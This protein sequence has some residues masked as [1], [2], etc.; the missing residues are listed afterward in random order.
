MARRKRNPYTACPEC[1]YN[2]PDGTF[3]RMLCPQCHTEVMLRAGSLPLA[4][5]PPPMPTQDQKDKLRRQLK[6]VDHPKTSYQAEASIT[7]KLGVITVCGVCGN[8]ANDH[9]SFANGEYTAKLL[10]F[11]RTNIC[12]HCFGPYLE[13]S[14]CELS[15]T[16]KCQ[17]LYH[18]RMKKV[19]S[20]LACNLLGTHTVSMD[21]FKQSPQLQVRVWQGILRQRGLLR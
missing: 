12:K 10:A 2:W 3:G 14:P 17:R 5:S 4:V 1:S 11:L 8:L 9:T 6:A 21:V 20:C 18:P 13:D 15:P 7:C 19:A 16:S